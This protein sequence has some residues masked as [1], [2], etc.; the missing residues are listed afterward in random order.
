[1]VVGVF[2]NIS[3][4]EI[5]LNNLS[6]AEFDPSK[7]SVVTNNPKE[8]ESISETTG[9]YT[10][11]SIQTLIAELQKKGL[12]KIISGQIF[13]VVETSNSEESAA[14]KEILESQNA[15]FV[16]IL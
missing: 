8:T 3:D 12:N 1:M 14:A 16:T 13:I 10:G 9:K 4:A 15:T 2:K 11:F 6:E 7:I 5:A